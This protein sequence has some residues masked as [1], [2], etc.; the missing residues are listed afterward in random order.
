MNRIDHLSQL[1][2]DSFISEITYLPF[3]DVVWVC[4]AND[5]L[6][7]FCSDPQYN[8]YW[9]SLID[10]TF[11]DVPHYQTK[12]KELWEKLKI[13]PDTYNYLVYTQMVK[14]LDLTTQ[15]MIYYRQGD[16]KSFDQLP[17]GDGDKL[18]LEIARRGYMKVLR[19]MIN[20]GIGNVHVEREVVLAFVSRHGHL[21]MVKYLVEEQKADIHGRSDRPLLWA[22]WF[23]HLD[24]VKYLLRKGADIHAVDDNALRVAS[25]YGHLD[26]VKYL[27]EQKA[28]Y[29]ARDDDALKLARMNGHLDVVKYLESLP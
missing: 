25:R 21:D 9:K 11:R 6:M 23:G 27:V 12:L 3:Q 15:A 24:V 16:I 10:D 18:L 8:P 7:S 19:H 1:P 28:D 4:S 29:H 2:I 14:L 13:N 26:V 5:K 22:S 17:Y 20:R